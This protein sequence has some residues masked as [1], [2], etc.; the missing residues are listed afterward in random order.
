ME[1]RIREKL[2][3]DG[4]HPMGCYYKNNLRNLQPSRWWRL[5]RHIGYKLSALLL[6]RSQLAEE[7]TQVLWGDD[8]ESDA[9]IYNLYSDIC[10]H[11]LDEASLILLFKKM[12]MAQD[13]VDLILQLRAL[14]PKGDPVQKFI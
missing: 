6:L 2:E 8:S 11:R 10:S 13:N 3:Y 12:G 7:V 14:I 4:I 1:E 5:N 9:V